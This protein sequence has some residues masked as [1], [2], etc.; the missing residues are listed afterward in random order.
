MNIDCQRADSYTRFR[1]ND[2]I[3]TLNGLTK[4]LATL[5]PTGVRSLEASSH[6]VGGQPLSSL[7]KCAAIALKA[8]KDVLA[9]AK[10]GFLYGQE[11]NSGQA[12]VD[13]TAATNMPPRSGAGVKRSCDRDWCEEFAGRETASKRARMTSTEPVRERD[14]TLESGSTNLYLPRGIDRYVPHE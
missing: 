8:L 11:S 5:Q 10:Y 13:R 3:A 14:H 6:P 4:S 7:Y 12:L 2:S 1:I 9:S